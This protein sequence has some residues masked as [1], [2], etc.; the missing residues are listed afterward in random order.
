MILTPLVTKAL[1]LQHCQKDLCF[2][3]VE[4]SVEELRVATVYQS[5]QVENVGI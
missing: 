3:T 1:Y 5:I 2:C 4:R